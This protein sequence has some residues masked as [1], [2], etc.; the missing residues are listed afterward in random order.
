MLTTTN[1]L[2]W[3]FVWIFWWSHSLWHKWRYEQWACHICPKWWSC[4]VYRIEN[5][6]RVLRDKKN[7]IFTKQVLNANLHLFE[8]NETT[9]FK[10]NFSS[11]DF[12]NIPGTVD[13]LRRT[14]QFMLQGSLKLCSQFD[15][16]FDKRHEKKHKIKSKTNCLIL[17]FYISKSTL[18]SHL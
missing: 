1:R 2:S 14:I 5:D 16:A 7:W 18:P 17:L 15:Y 9:G 13:W 8:T 10:Q 6:L 3:F 4:A 12:W 11:R